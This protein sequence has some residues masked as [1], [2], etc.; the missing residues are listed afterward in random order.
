MV[1]LFFIIELITML[2]AL[3]QLCAAIAYRIPR[4]KPEKQTFPEIKCF[5][6]V[7][8]IAFKEKDV[9]YVFC[10]ILLFLKKVTALYMANACWQRKEKL[11][12]TREILLKQNDR[13]VLLVYN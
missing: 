8:I 9:S 1:L 2:H 10:S 7:R 4:K 5:R 12:K 13:L 6:L 3:L 11:K